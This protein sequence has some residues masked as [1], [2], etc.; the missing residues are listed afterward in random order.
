VTDH[1]VLQGDGLVLELDGVRL[2]APE[3][4]LL[5]I[6]RERVEDATVLD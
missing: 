1:A 5:G 2:L 4:D 6:D 3:E